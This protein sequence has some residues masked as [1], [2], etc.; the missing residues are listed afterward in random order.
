MAAPITRSGRRLP[1]SIS[2]ACSAR[3]AGRDAL[4]SYAM[5]LLTGAATIAALLP[6][7]SVLFL[8]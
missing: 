7:F 4:F 3:C 8:L 1:R 2:R 6:F 5:S